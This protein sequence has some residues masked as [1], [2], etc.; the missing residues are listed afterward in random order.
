MSGTGVANFGI[1]DAAFGNGSGVEGGSC[2]PVVSVPAECIGATVTVYDPLLAPGFMWAADCDLGLPGVQDV[3][4]VPLGTGSK[5]VGAVVLL[6]GGGDRKIASMYMQTTTNQLVLD[7]KPNPVPHVDRDA[8]P[9]WNQAPFLAAEP[10]PQDQWACSPFYPVPDGNSDPAVASSAISCFN[11]AVPGSPVLNDDGYSLL[12][13]TVHYNIAASSPSAAVISF[14]YADASDENFVTLGACTT[15][16]VVP[17]YPATVYITGSL[18]DTDGDTRNNV[19]DNCVE[20]PNNAQANNDRIVDLPPSK[21]FDDITRL[22]GDNYGDVCDADDD[23]DGLRDGRESEGPPCLTASAATDPMKSDTDG[24]RALDGAE[25]LLGFDP[26]NAAS[27]PPF[28][29]PLAIDMDR[30]G[31]PDSIEASLGMDPADVDTDNDTV[32]DGV[33][34]KYYNGNAANPD[35]DGDGCND[36]KEVATVNADN[37]VNAIDLG[38]VASAFGNVGAPQYLVEFDMNK[39]G[40]ISSLDLGRVAVQFGSC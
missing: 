5:D 33:E 11:G 27:T 37:V 17:C 30:D 28:V 16:P 34:L 4:G 14:D 36:G 8:N 13:F 29:F 6:N 7:P 21:A 39:D 15:D 18:F 38:Q 10:P 24:D 26:A 35:T 20:I 31:V 32:N 23:N 22:H 9:D 40:S 1:Q 3:C 25:C 2:N 19:I 12:A